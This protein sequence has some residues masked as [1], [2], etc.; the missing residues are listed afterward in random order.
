MVSRIV[1][2][3]IAV[4]LFVRFFQHA[5][6]QNVVPRFEPSDCDFQIPDG[7]E[8]ECGHLIV[9]ENRSNPDSRTISLGVA[10][11]HSTS[12]HPEPD[13]VVYLIGEPGGSA[14]EYPSISFN[15]RYHEFLSN[16]D[17]IVFDQRGAQHSD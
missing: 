10:I 12:A 14:L 17:Y 4:L 6:A 5:E 1:V 2:C 9:S 8:P 7:Y 13:P 16:R 11:Y 15:Q 3:L